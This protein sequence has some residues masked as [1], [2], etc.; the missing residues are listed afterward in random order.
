MDHCAV[1][2]GSGGGFAPRAAGT[3]GWGPMLASP[4]VLRLTGLTL[5]WLGNALV[6]V[7]PA[8]PR[9]DWLPAA[10]AAAGVGVVGVL[11]I[12]AAAMQAAR[13]RRR[14]RAQDREL[15]EAFERRREA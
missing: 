4:R 9:D 10:C 6:A 2:G 3:L 5:V 13:V 8:L 1:G 14:T 7:C 11:L 15:L 12:L